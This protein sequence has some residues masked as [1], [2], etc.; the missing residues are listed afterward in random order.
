MYAIEVQVKELM[1]AKERIG[2][3]EDV[4]ELKE[5]TIRSLQHKLGQFQAEGKGAVMQKPTN[6]NSEG[7]YILS[8]F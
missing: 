8:R 3:L 2:T 5:H 6:I 4:L 7:M 1:D